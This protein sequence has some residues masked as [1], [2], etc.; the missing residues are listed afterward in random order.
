MGLLQH[1][2]KAAHLM[3]GKRGGGGSDGQF[4]G[5]VTSGQSELHEPG[6]GALERS[7]LSV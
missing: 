5:G 4:S 3:L 6:Y 2:R 1:V 7:V